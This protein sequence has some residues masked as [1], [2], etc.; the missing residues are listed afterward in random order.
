MIFCMDDLLSKFHKMNNY[1][2]KMGPLKRP[3]NDPKSP[4]SLSPSMKEIVL[5]TKLH[6]G[7]THMAI[8][9]IWTQIS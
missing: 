8:L 6:R 2:V 3:Y 4:Q 7:H 5:F 1:I 9:H